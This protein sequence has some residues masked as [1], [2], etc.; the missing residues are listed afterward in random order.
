[1]KLKFISQSGNN[2][3]GNLK[4]LRLIGVSVSV[5]IL[6]NGVCDLI[7]GYSSELS[8]IEYLSP[9]AIDTILTAGHRPHWMVMLAQTA[10]WLYP[11][12]ALLFYHWWVGMR[13]AGFWLAHVPCG[14]LAYAAVMIGGIQHAGWAFLS[15]LGRAR[16]VV[17]STDEA[18]YANPSAVEPTLHAWT[19]SRVSW[20]HV[21][22]DLKKYQEGETD[23][24]L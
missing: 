19:S 1:M 21:N 12:Y 10:G 7:Y 17:G 2:E 6:W 11:I 9:T 16:E 22:D 3:E 13:R 18:F 8:G 4:R 23:S 15:V 24:G 20:L 14:L 5:L